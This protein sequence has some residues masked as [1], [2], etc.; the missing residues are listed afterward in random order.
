VAKLSE[1]F[2]PGDRV[3][4]HWGEAGTVAKTTDPMLSGGGTVQEF[5]DDILAGGSDVVVFVWLDEHKSGA[6]WYMEEDV[7]FQPAFPGIKSYDGYSITIPAGMAIT[8]AMINDSGV[9]V[10]TRKP[11]HT[12]AWKPYYGLSNFVQGYDC[13]CGEKRD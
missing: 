7:A 4:T 8:G 12:H 3:E 9:T 1:K 10:T 2:K 13:E 5:L 6:C 11:A